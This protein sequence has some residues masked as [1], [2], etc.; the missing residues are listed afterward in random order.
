MLFRGATAVLR[1]TNEATK[2]REMRVK[3]LDTAVPKEPKRKDERR[4]LDEQCPVEQKKVRDPRGH[5][6]S[7]NGISPEIEPVLGYLDG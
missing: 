4:G 7:P 1:N 5:I 6:S 2:S 3:G